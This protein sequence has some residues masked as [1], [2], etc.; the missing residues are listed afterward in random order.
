MNCWWK[1]DVYHWGVG[2]FGASLEKKHLFTKAGLKQGIHGRNG[3]FVAD[4]E[5]KATASKGEDRGWNPMM[6]TV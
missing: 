4:K 6:S 3:K 2:D 1:R 5:S